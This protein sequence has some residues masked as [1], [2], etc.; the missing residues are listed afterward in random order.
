L[1]PLDNALYDDYHCLVALNKQQIKW[2]VQVSTGKLE[3]ELR[4][5]RIHVQNIAS[6]SLSHDRTIKMEQ[7]N[8]QRGWEK[9]RYSNERFW[10]SNRPIRSLDGVA[11]CNAK[12][13]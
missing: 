5:E 9:L 8:K 4:N 11:N 10:E 3:V 2:E 7:I 12:F 1:R 6:P 13:K